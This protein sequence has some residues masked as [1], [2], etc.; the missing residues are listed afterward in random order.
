MYQFEPEVKVIKTGSPGKKTSFRSS[1][2]QMFLKIA[3]CKKLV[4]YTGKPLYWSL[5]LIMLQFWGPETL[6]K[7]TQAEV[8]PFEICKIFKNNCFEEHLWTTVS[9]FSLKRNS[10]TGVFLWILWIIQ[11]HLFCRASTSYWFWNNSRGSIYQVNKVASLRAWR[12]LTVLQKDYNIGISLWVLGKHFCRTTPS[13]HF[14]HDVLFFLPFIR[15]QGL[16]YTLTAWGTRTGR[17][18]WISFSVFLLQNFKFGCSLGAFYIW[19]ALN[20]LKCVLFG[21]TACSEIFSL[22][23][24]GCKTFRS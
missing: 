5:F 15:S 18:F 4:N 2:M 23:Y 1:R 8:F 17:P 13:N 3:I 10:N 21:H 19:I 22:F 16:F 14:W 9:K 20:L 6:L 11:E 24:Q 12:P 7:K